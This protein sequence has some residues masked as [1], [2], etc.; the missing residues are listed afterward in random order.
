[1]DKINAQNYV[2]FFKKVLKKCLKV[3]SKAIHL[4]HLNDGRVRNREK[5]CVLSEQKLLFLENLMQNT[6][7]KSNSVMHQ[8]FCIVN[9]NNCRPV[10]C[11]TH[12]VWVIMQI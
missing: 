3:F 4:P 12:G 6:S 9:D 8:L 1:M 10:N 11:V 7:T 2:K 5:Y